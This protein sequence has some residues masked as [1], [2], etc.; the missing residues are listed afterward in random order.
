MKTTEFKIGTFTT[1]N[2]NTYKIKEIIVNTRLNMFCD[3]PVMYD[4]VWLDGETRAFSPRGI[5]SIIK[6]S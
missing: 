1:N 6:N 2:G 3:E 5:R 4:V